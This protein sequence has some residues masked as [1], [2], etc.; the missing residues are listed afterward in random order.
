VPNFVFSGDFNPTREPAS[1]FLF[2]G[3]LV[4]HKGIL[5]LIRAMRQLPQAQFVVA[6]DGPLRS[7]VERMAQDQANQIRIVGFR[8]GAE[9]RDLLENCLAVIVPSEWYENCPYS[10]LEAMAA[11]RAVLASRIGGNPELV[12]N[13][14]NGLLFTPGDE[15]GLVEKMAFLWQHRDEAI[16]MGAAGRSLVE[17]RYSPDAHYERMFEIMRGLTA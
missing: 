2:A 14:C 16:Q 17:K 10:I 8:D 12:A 5:T 6:G 13:G 7:E 9:L 11:G 4:R 1:Y 3:R 15:R